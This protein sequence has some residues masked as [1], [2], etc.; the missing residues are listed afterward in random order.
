MLVNLV[1]GHGKAHSQMFLDSGGYQ[2]E[3][4]SVVD[5]EDSITPLTPAVTVVAVGLAMSKAMGRYE[6]SAIGIAKVHSLRLYRL[7][8]QLEVLIVQ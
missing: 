5:V 6:I 1:T 4:V 8:R 7:D 3:V 2:R